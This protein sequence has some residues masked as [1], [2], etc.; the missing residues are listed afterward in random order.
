[1]LLLDG[2]PESN[3]KKSDDSYDSWE[4]HNRKPRPKPKQQESPLS[5]INGKYVFLLFSNDKHELI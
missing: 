4:D 3:I 2:M 1:M 5:T